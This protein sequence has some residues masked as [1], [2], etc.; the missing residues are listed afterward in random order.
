MSNWIRK[1]L[2]TATAIAAAATFALPAQAQTREL[3]YAIGQPPS[4]LPVIGG[5]ELAK[6][7]ARSLKA[8]S[9]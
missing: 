7:V 1:A 6:A 2:C 9:P 5:Q 8:S 4:A 3:R